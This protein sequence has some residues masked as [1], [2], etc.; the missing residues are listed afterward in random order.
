LL[1]FL[2]PRRARRWN[3]LSLFFALAT[4]GILSGCG[5]GGVEPANLNPGTLTAGS[6]TVT[7]SATGG[8]LIQTATINLAI[9]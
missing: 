6:Y 8:S 1:F 7:V 4:L 2:L 3:L 5:S 9:Q